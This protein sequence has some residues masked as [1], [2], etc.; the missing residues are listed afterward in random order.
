MSLQ[1]IERAKTSWDPFR[2]FGQ[3]WSESVLTS[4]GFLYA[5]VL[6]W[7]VEFIFCVSAS[8]DLKSAVANFC[9]LWF[10]SGAAFFTGTICGI[11]FGLP[12]S[13]FVVARDAVVSDKTTPNPAINTTRYRANTNFEDVSD[14]L[15]KIVVGLGIA[16]FP[17]LI[18]FF[19]SVGDSVGPELSVGKGASAIVSSSL[20]YGLVCGFLYYYVW[21]RSTLQKLLEQGETGGV[22]VQQ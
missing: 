10:V 6:A 12:R 18:E 4:G 14:W 19:V 8:Q 17:K 21:A 1:P 13:Q 22:P 16:Q 15:S 20:I 2:R 7:S 5:V 11:L 3:Y 9:I